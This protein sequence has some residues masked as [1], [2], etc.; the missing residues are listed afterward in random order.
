MALGEKLFLALFGRLSSVHK[1]E[2]W[3]HAALHWR[4]VCIH[5]YFALGI[6][7][8]TSESCVLVLQGRFKEEE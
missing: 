5:E 4:F 1:N 8:Q 3:P 2:P 6:E 7:F